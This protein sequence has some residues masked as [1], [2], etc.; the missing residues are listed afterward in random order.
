[1]IMAV[2]NLGY[3][4]SYESGGLIS[5]WLGIKEGNYENLWAQI[6]IATLFPLVM[7]VAI[8]FVPKDFE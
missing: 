6:L 3:L 7:L 8:L 1:V 2:I 4:I 5:N